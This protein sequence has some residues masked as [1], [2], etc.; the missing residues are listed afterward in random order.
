MVLGFPANDFAGQGPGTAETR[1]AEG[2]DD[3]LFQALTRHAGI[4]PQ[5]NFH[6]YLI[7][8]KGRLV[9]HFPGKVEPLGGE[10]AQRVK[11]LL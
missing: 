2:A 7:G 6:K 8:R 9:A 5:W 11:E 1:V 10:L 3:P 4:Y